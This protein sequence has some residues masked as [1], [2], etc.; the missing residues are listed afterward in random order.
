MNRWF[1]WLALVVVVL[2]MVQPALLDPPSDG[3]PFSTYPM[4]SS[5]RGEVTTIATAVGRT[6]EA[7]LVRLSPMALAGTD[8]PILAVKTARVAVSSGE[9]EP[10]CR[11]VAQRVARGS[12][13]QGPS[14]DIITIEVVTETHDTAAT[15]V[16]NADALDVTVHAACAVDPQSQ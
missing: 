7:E 12:P 8:E 15:M 3:F 5:D 14:S 10:W 1:P 13:V 11:E 6:A 16:H 4:F 2:A 9:S